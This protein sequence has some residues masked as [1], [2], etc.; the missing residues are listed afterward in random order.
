MSTP[1]EVETGDLGD[2]GKTRLGD[3]TYDDGK[4]GRK[5]GNTENVLEVKKKKKV[6]KGTEEGFWAKIAKLLTSSKDKSIGLLQMWYE[7]FTLPGGVKGGFAAVYIVLVAPPLIIKLVFK[8]IDPFYSFFAKYSGLKRFTD[9]LKRKANDMKKGFWKTYEKDVNALAAMRDKHPVP[10]FIASVITFPIALAA[11]PFV[12]V[13]IAGQSLYEYLSG[14]SEVANAEL[15]SQE[16][17]EKKEGNKQGV[18]EEKDLGKTEK[19]GLGEEQSKNATPKKE[20]TKGSFTFNSNKDVDLEGAATAKKEQSAVKPETSSKLGN[21]KA[22]GSRLS[23]S[24]SN[25][26]S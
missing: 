20:N 7:D 10:Y 25:N 3:E 8:I 14:T 15:P 26:A 21:G 23:R 24:G 5:G 6:I 12:M 9:H 22:T 1:L 19:Q 17:K 18:G 13:G 4:G 11:S 16:E 2:A